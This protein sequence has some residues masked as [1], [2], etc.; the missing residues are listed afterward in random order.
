M[1]LLLDNANE[2]ADDA[3]ND[4]VAANR[5]R[6]MVIYFAKVMQWPQAWSMGERMTMAKKQKVKDCEML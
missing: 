1:K 5:K 2:D 4:V 3:N 6:C